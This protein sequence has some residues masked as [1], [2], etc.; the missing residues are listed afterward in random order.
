MASMRNWAAL[1]AATGVVYGLSAYLQAVDPVPLLSL[2]S[3]LRL[4]YLTAA[5]HLTYR[6]VA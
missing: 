5:G 1:L 3:F 2:P 4:I 6:I